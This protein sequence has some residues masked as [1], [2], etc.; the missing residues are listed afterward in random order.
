LAYVN[1]NQHHWLLLYVS[2]SLLFN[3][4]FLVK[5]VFCTCCFDL[6]LIFNVESSWHLEIPSTNGQAPRGDLINNLV[7]L[8]LKCLATHLTILVA[9]NNMFKDMNLHLRIDHLI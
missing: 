6:Q 5:D 8:L 2:K 3:W 7:R 1:G 4:I 9:L